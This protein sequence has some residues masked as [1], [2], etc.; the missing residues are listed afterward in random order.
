MT[1]P[2]EAMLGGLLD[3]F[4]QGFAAGAARAQDFDFFH[5][6]LLIELR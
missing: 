5:G 4:G 2:S 3:H 6:G 1:M